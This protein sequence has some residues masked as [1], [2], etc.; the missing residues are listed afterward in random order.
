M[1]VQDEIIK[2]IKMMVSKEVENQKN[3]SIASV[4]TE[5]KGNKYKVIVDGSEY[6]VKDGV[7]L[8][9]TIGTSVWLY[10]PNG[11]INQMFIMA[12]R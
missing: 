6:W 12:K 2:T 4:V 3:L 7:N 11:N 5:V 8:N 9:P 10:K 1:N